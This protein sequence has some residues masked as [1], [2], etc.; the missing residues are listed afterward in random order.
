MLEKWEETFHFVLCFSLH[1]F[2]ALAAS[3][4]LIY[5]NKTEHISWCISHTKEPVITLS[6]GRGKLRMLGG[7]H[8]FQGEQSGNQ[9]L[10]TE[11][12][13]EL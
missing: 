5:Y 13:G 8:G 12:E 9:S 7:S 1:L 2:R 11:Y 4:V 3:Y 10:P 6:R